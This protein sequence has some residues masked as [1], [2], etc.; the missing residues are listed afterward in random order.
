MFAVGLPWNDELIETQS[1]LE[2]EQ[3]IT[4]SQIPFSNDP[5]PKKHLLKHT[6]FWCTDVQSHLIKYGIVSQHCHRCWYQKKPVQYKIIQFEK[7][8]KL[9]FRL[10][11]ITLFRP[12]YKKTA[13]LQPLNWAAPGHS[14]ISI[15]MEVKEIKGTMKLKGVG[16]WR[17]L[18]FLEIIR[19]IQKS[20]K[21]RGCRVWYCRKGKEEGK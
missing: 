14:T 6:L 8:V 17:G 12:D 9:D 16:K 4:C 18:C 15:G 3:S 11:L 5:P 20:K 7:A 10:F 1:V 2:I 19:V 13:T 21:I